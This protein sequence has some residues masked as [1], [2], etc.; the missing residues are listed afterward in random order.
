M[1]LLT[2]VAHARSRAVSVR[3]PSAFRDGAFRMGPR[4]V[5]ANLILSVGANDEQSSNGEANAM[6]SGGAAGGRQSPGGLHIAIRPRPLTAKLSP[7]KPR[8]ATATP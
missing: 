1:V 6:I 4:C 2:A 7:V 8:L 3:R 5:P